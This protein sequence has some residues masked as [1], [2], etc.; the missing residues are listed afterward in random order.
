MRR[1]L[2]GELWGRCFAEFGTSG[3]GIHID[4]AGTKCT[5]T[6]MTNWIPEEAERGE[7]YLVDMQPG[8]AP[9]A[10]TNGAGRVID[11]GGST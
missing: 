5:F 1:E 3:N 11:G 9:V 10:L 8:S 4:S 2:I 7:Y 6:A